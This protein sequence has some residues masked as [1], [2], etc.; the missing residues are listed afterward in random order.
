MV[1]V[2]DTIVGRPVM[3]AVQFTP[4]SSLWTNRFDPVGAFTGS[5]VLG[6]R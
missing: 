2:P 1:F 5:A 3:A 4:P 6:S